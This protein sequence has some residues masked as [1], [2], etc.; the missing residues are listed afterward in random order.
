MMP[1]ALEED[2]AFAYS[3]QPRAPR[4]ACDP[5]YIVTGGWGLQAVFLKDRKDAPSPGAVPPLAPEKVYGLQSEIGDTSEESIDV[6]DAAKRKRARPSKAK[7]KRFGRFL[8][9]LEE[10]AREGPA[11]FE[12]TCAEAT[13][14]SD[15]NS[16]GA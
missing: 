13:L 9:K 2:V 7:R 5:M 4:A 8:A 10:E 14:Q 15:Q 3:G 1:A 12:A 11:F 6:E 16:E